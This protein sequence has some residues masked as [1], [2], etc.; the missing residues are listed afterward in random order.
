MLKHTLLVSLFLILTLLGFSQLN[1][2][3]ISNYPF[4]ANRG[5][6]TDV[7]GYVDELNNEYAI[8]GM[9]TGVA[10][11]DISTPAS[12]V[13][14]FY[15]PGPNSGWRDIKVWKDVAYITNES[16]GGLMMIDMTKL[17]GGTIIAGD[18][19]S[20]GGVTYPF[21]KAHNIYVDENGIGYV[22]GADNGKG[23]AIIIDLDTDPLNPTEL[24]R[25]D[26]YYVHD[27]MVRGDTMWVGCINDGFFAAVDVS[28]KA[29][30][31]TMA[32]H[33]TPGL[34]SHNCWISDDG[35]YLFTTDEKS[36]AYIGAFDVSNFSNITE[37]DRIQS[38]PGED[39]I[40]HNA[41]Y[42]NGYVITSYYR[43]GVTIHDVSNPSNMVE[44][45]NYDTSP[46][47]SGNGFNG[48]WGVYPY[49]PSG[50]I[51]ASDIENGLFVLGPTY[52]K[53]AYLEGNVT[54]SISA[55]VL[56]GVQI[57]IDTTNVVANTNVLGD[58]KIGIGVP[59]T[60]NITYEK[61]AYETKTL[62]NVVLTANNTV[63]LD[64]ELVPL[65]TF[66][67][68]GEVLES[69][70]LNPIADAIVEIQGDMFSTI[71]QTDVSGSFS[72][73]NLLEGDYSIYIT[74]WGHGVVCIDSA[75]L[76]SATNPH[77]YQLDKKYY[78][79][80]TFDLGWV[81]SGSATSGMWER[82]V[83]EGTTYN[84]TLANP[85]SDVNTDCNDKAYV[86]GNLGGGAGSD[87]VDGGYTKL[88]SPI[89]D[90]STY[91]NPYLN[92]YRWF[93][94]DGG[95]GIPNDSLVISMSNGATTVVLDRVEFGAPNLSTWVSKSIR[96]LD[97][98]S[99]SATMQLIVEATD[100]NPGHLV[101]A[102]FD[103]FEII[104]MPTG[105]KE[106]SLNA[107]I[108]I[109]P[110]PFNNVINIKVIQNY[111]TIKVQLFEITGQLMEE[112]QFNNKSDF[113]IKNN[114]PKGVY[115]INIY[116]DGAL[117]TTQK[118]IKL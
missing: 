26:D 111:S 7:W 41:F 49:L 33:N 64:V 27:A 100:F 34:Y 4:P 73:N 30:P 2:N 94:N 116:G 44:V 91:T 77:Q 35:K 19:S 84:S 110:N 11:V 117:I 83:P 51:I 15:T 61:Y 29:N 79:D 13:E 32:T 22:V 48:C 103:Q 65:P 8:V 28:N 21:T 43:D 38:S 113:Q 102:G 78:D 74:K 9:Q 18:V 104:D 1:I 59:G 86:T 105:V 6:V 90:L 45:G 12:P 31:I 71:L 23:G 5:E 53:G 57:T 20:Y 96:L 112:Q 54:D 39:V 56:D 47:Y 24:G 82:G 109:Y 55:G 92:Y 88:E 114:Y 70:T 97:Y 17:P 14:V 85:D 95:S 69:L 52:V 46:A 37:V 98:L 106:E 58:Y 72:I 80:F 66:N 50:L 16:S 93:F 81:A 115:F 68:Q 99:L 40:P 3:L 108:A 107:G 89:I 118:L 75:F 101:E 87:D 42:L 25:Y 60:Y 10:I 62:N 76:S 63:T 67:F 36:N